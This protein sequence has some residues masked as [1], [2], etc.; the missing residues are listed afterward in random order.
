MDEQFNRKYRK[1]LEILP[2]V[3]ECAEGKL[4]LVGGTALA[5]FHLKHRISIDLDFVPMEGDDAKLKQE[6]KGC[7]SKKG[8]RAARAVYA[9]QFVIQFEDTSIKVEVF[10]PEHKVRNFEEYEVGNAKLAVASLEDI[11]EMKLI[12]YANR[13]AA[14]DLFDIIFVLKKKG[15]DFGQVAELIAKYGMPE[16]IKDVKNMALSENDYEIFA[17]VVGDAS[18]AGN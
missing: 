7:L 13:K 15:A 11:F 17:K 18:K 1:V 12:A 16:D 5:L 6:L 2:D 9:N 4:I 8:Y 3:A 14:R 10:I